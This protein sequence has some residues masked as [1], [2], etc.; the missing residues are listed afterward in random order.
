MNHSLFVKTDGSLWACG[1]NSYGQLGAGTG[2]T[3]K[4]PTPKKIMDDVISV[5][6][7]YEHSFIIKSDASLWV[8]G[9]NDY[10]QLGDGTTQNCSSPKKIMDGVAAAST[11]RVHSLIVKTDKS[12][13]TC[14]SNSS[15][16]LFDG[17]EW[18]SA[19]PI[20]TI[21]SSS[22]SL[23]DS[24]QIFIRQEASGI[25]NLSGQKLTTPQ[26]GIN[27]INGKK[28]VIK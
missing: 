27:I 11:G 12:L 25:Y 8:C 7:K 6:A 4:Q 14:G 22:P 18:N 21:G 23:V 5:S 20:M 28:V 16:K 15:G 9:E 17:T 2:T 13:W 3:T 10:G 19:T 1:S 26:K 24:P